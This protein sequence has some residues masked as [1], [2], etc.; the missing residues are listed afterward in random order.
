LN[1][2][3]MPNWLAKRALLTPKRIALRTDEKTWTFAELNMRSCKTAQRVAQFG[4]NKHDHVALLVQNSMLMAEVI[5]AL[6]YL[7][8]VLI[9]LNTRLTSYEL[10]WQVK[11]ANASYLIYDEAFEKQADAIMMQIPDLK[12]VSLTELLELQGMDVLL[13]HEF[14]LDQVHTIIYTSGTTGH[15]KGVML[16]YGNHWWSAIG[17]SLNLG[18]HMSDC[19]LLCVPMYHVSGLSILM[20]NIIY[21]ITV[22]VHEEF[23]PVKVNEAIRHRQITMISVVSVMLTQ[24]LHNL[25]PANYP[26]TLRCVLLGGGFVPQSL[27]AQCKQHNIPLFQTYGMTETAS[28]IATLS[29]DFLQLKPDSAGKALFPVQMKIVKE[30]TEQLPMEEGEIIVKGPNVTKGYIRNQAETEKMIHDGWLFT[31][32]WGYLDEDGF[33]YVLDR[34]A[35][36]IISGGE[37]IYPA[38]VESMILRHPAIEDAGVIGMEDKKWGKVPVAFVKQ[39]DGMQIKEEELFDFCRQRLAGYKVPMAF[40]FINELPRNASNKLLRMR[41]HELLP[42]RRL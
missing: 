16:T 27:I 6:E 39:K 17:S 22:E 34:R 10:A 13:S 42:N 14:A 37:N 25:G 1:S 18:L 29:P 2:Q 5:H 3:R 4:A 31:G 7:G 20:R 41:L 38:E 35:D 8:A 12:I 11:D 26:E 9:L 40:Y 33:L 32:D 19:W 23:N 30:N 21:G 36:L 15:P 24:M 28:Q